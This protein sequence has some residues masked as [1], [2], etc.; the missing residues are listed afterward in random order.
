MAID[1]NRVRQQFPVLNAWAYLNTAS[2]GPLPTYAVNA[3]AVHYQR[4]DEEACLDFLDWYSDIEV[5]RARAAALVGADA[6][7]VAF[8]P[9]AGTALSWLMNGIDWKPGD[10]ILSL[11]DEFPNNLYSAGILESRGVNFTRASVPEG[12]FSTE[13][14]LAQ[15]TDRTRLVLLSAVNYSSGLR[16][17]LEP[18]GAALRERGVLLYVDGTQSVGALPTDVQ[19]SCVDVLAAHGYKWLCSPMGTGFV[20]VHPEVREWLEPSIYSWRSHRGWRDVDH[21]HH[22]IPELPDAAMKYEGGGQNFAGLYAMGAV[23]DWL[24]LLGHEQ[25]WEHVAQVTAATRDVLRRRGAVLLDDL[26]PH[27]DSSIIAA[28]F[29]GQDASALAAELKQRRIAVAARKGNLRVSPHFFNNQDDLQRLD[30]ALT[31]ILER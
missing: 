22:G 31:E 2:F 12:C 1:H 21:L 14:F 8:I 25:V 20:Y 18:I 17:P 10:H 11:S 29:E 6:E 19:R 28:K 23:L 7:D 24:E 13:E 5:I 15:I 27:Y 30:S 26:Q 4:R 3:A 16:P 9:N